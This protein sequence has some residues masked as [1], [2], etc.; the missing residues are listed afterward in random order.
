MLARPER[1]RC[2]ECSRVYG[3]ADFAYHRGRIEEGPA[4]W[5]DRGLLCSIECSVKH[6]QRRL[7]DGTAPTEPAGNPLE[8]ETVL[9]R[10]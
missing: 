9:R 6:Y 2:L 8:Y 1:L 7:A 3:S 4:Y 5:S 10:R